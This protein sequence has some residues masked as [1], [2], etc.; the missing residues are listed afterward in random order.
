MDSIDRLLLSPELTL[1]LTIF[2]LT[3]AFFA[4]LIKVV[5]LLTKISRGD[6]QMKSLLNGINK[7]I[8][9]PSNEDETSQMFAKV[10]EELGSQAKGMVEVVNQLAVVSA[11]NQKT[12]ENNS[13]IKEVRE[14][15]AKEVGAF[16]DNTDENAQIAHSSSYQQTDSIHI[17][18]SGV[19]LPEPQPSPGEDA[20][21]SEGQDKKPEEPIVNPPE[22]EDKP[23]THQEIRELLKDTNKF[24]EVN[25]TLNGGI[26]SVKSGEWVFDGEGKLLPP[27]LVRNIINIFEKIV[28]CESPTAEQQKI[29]ECLVLVRKNRNLA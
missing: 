18:Y 3:I 2:F 15:L 28:N 13:N 17:T 4:I 27:H 9:T 5:F 20:N 19:D 12:S 24:P 23:F 22:K 14:V 16:N 26:W 1:W 7:G 10:G 8:T 11:V 6:P 29:Y 21:N 25:K